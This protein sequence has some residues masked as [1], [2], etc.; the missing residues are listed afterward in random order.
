LVRHHRDPAPHASELAFVATGSFEGP[1]R[2]EYRWERRYATDEW[3]TQLETHSDHALMAPEA[4]GRLLSAVG[5][6]LEE[7]GG[8]F[9]MRYTCE[10]TRFTRR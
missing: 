6:L 7:R 3:L 10:V 8:G 9:T 5:D 1:E 2:T 4:R